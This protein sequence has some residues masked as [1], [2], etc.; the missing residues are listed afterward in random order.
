LVGQTIDDPIALAAFRIQDAY[1][2]MQELNEL[3][4]GR[5][6]LGDLEVARDDGVA[7]LQTTEERQQRTREREERVEQEAR[8]RT[9]REE[10]QQRRRQIAA[11]KQQHA[12]RA[13]Q[14]KRDQEYRFGRW[15]MPAFRSLS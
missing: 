14:E 13:R 12:T 2:E 11:A 6:T 15:A 7:F 10:E 1:D 4:L 8:E 5:R 3:F 9:E